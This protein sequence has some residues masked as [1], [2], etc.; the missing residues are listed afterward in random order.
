M[1]I[2]QSFLVTFDRALPLVDCAQ[3]GDGEDTF[4]ACAEADGVF[5][6][7]A[8]GSESDESPYF[9]SLPP[10]LAGLEDVV[11]EVAEPAVTFLPVRFAVLPQVSLSEG[12]T[13]D[14]T[15]T[16][17]SF[18]ASKSART[19]LSLLLFPLILVHDQ[20]RRTSLNESCSHNPAPCFTNQPTWKSHGSRGD[21]GSGY[22]SLLAGFRR[23]NETV[24]S[25]A[26]A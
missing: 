17:C 21:C 20:T 24:V 3:L 6:S 23:E 15:A 16:N 22:A 9:E 14:G 5:H 13:T 11:I 8:S 19:L 1:K 12:H 2:Q 7:Q 4:H 18:K 26:S 25:S 10:S